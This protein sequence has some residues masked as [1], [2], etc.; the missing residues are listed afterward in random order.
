M[1]DL[2]LALLPRK[3]LLLAPPLTSAESV[4]GGG[5]L[6]ES[7]LS[8]SFFSLQQIDGSPAPRRHRLL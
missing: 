6:I 4:I 5:W 3:G 1:A 7:A 8:R 2:P